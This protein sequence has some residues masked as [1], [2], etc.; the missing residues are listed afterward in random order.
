MQSLEFIL[1]FIVVLSPLV[2]VHEFGH[3][4]VAKAFGIEVP[5]FSIGFGPRLVGFRRKETDYR[6][7][8]IPLGGYVR[9]A[10]DEADENRTG[11]PREFLSRPRW[12]RFLVFVAGATVN[13]IVALIVTWV[14]LWNWGMWEA[15]SPE[16]FP[17]IVEIAEESTAMEAGLLVGDTVVSVA[18]KDARELMTFR[19]EVLLSPDTVKPVVIE[20]EGERITIPLNTGA[21]PTYRLGFPGWSFS[22]DPPVIT[23]VLGDSAAAEAGLERGDWVL[24]VGQRELT[25]V[26][27]LQEI[28]AK[29]AGL[30]IELKIDREGTTE[31]II[32]VPRE[33]DGKGLIGVSLQS[34]SFVHRDLTA[35][36]AVGEAWSLNVDLVQTVFVTLRRLVGGDISVRALSGPIEIARYSRRAVENMRTF[37]TFLA[38]LSLQLGILNLL[39]IPV[40]DG[41]HILILGVEGVLRRD[42]SMR[43]KERVM[44]VGLVF[45]LLVFGF[46]IYFDAIKA[47]LGETMQRLFSS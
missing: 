38:F 2:F 33:V 37:L 46:V 44:Q 1:A 10:G 36:E 3:F 32:V 17:V 23:E 31:H 12:Q 26:M 43:L 27:E 19:D 34:G 20:R 28:L 11:H 18:G 29:S 4:I 25:G 41:G 16:A 7:S 42:L 9:M 8:L 21:D 15:R 14:V 30:E 35:L 47:G 45:L 39:P 24:A 6:I 40:L 22:T 5:V 13:I